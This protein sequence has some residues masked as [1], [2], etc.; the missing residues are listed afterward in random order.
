MKKIVS[1]SSIFF[2]ALVMLYSCK[3]DYFPKVTISDNTPVSF[4]TDIYPIFS[5]SCLG[6]NCHSGGK[7][8]NLGTRDNAYQNLVEGG[9]VDTLQ[10]DKSMLYLKM[11]K[12]PVGQIMPQ[13]GKLPGDQTEL[14]LLWIKKGAQDN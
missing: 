3:K 5:K 2:L 7:N 6:S 14:V 8:P 13:T 9:Y 1:I 10:P 4:T 12:P 11:T